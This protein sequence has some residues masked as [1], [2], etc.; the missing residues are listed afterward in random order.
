M[1]DFHL[2][3]GVTKIA[4]IILPLVCKIVV[5]SEVNADA[6]GLA[7]LVRAPGCGSGGREFNPLSS[8]HEK[9]LRL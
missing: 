9:Y 1:S 8:P 5:K 7:Q 6:A 3:G 2:R 4:R